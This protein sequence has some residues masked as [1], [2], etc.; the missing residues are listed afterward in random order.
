[1]RT[2]KR[3][4]GPDKHR[5]R[6]AGPAMLPTCT[7]ETGVRNGSGS[8]QDSH[9]QDDDDDESDGEPEALEEQ[10][11]L[12]SSRTRHGKRP[13]EPLAPEFAII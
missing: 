13:A 11:D 4:R 8:A 3:G 7:N 2:S 1:M 12:V 9:A 10:A 5:V 6:T